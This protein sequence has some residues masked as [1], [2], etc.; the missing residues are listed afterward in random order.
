MSIENNIIENYSFERDIS[1]KEKCLL[2]SIGNNSRIATPFEAINP[3]LI[4]IGDFVSI[5]RDM[6]ISVFTD[7]T[8]VIDYVGQ[9]Y[10]GMEKALNKEDY[11]FGEPEVS[12]GD[13]TSFG[14]FCFITA[15]NEIRIGRGVV[16]S[17]RV[18]ITDTE[19]RFENPDLPILY[20]SMTKNGR[21][22]IGDH[23]WVGIG[24]VII[25]ARIGRN[26]VIGANS[27]VKSDIPDYTVAVGSPARPVKRYSFKKKCWE[28]I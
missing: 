6:K 26:C 7:I 10:P 1:E 14:R 3:Q 8:R 17:D 24:A 21:V 28:S 19:H 25:N 18:Y 20:Q 15:T 13:C 4:S 23:S 9:H 11:V 27:V 12:I 22:E 5:N 16:F 2:K